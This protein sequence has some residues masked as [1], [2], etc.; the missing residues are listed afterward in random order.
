MPSHMFIYMRIMP[1][2]A[3]LTPQKLTNIKG[4]VI[5]PPPKFQI[6]VQGRFNGPNSQTNVQGRFNDPDYA[7][8]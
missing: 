1:N 6:N 8:V 3:G 4:A 5:T 2:I 7:S